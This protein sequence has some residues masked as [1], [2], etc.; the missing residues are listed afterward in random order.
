MG[1]AG[2]APP[3]DR[4]DVGDAA[5]AARQHLVAEHL[6]HVPG[7][8]EV[9]LDHRVPALRR[10][11]A[12]PLRELAA[13]VVHQQVNGADALLHPHRQGLDRLPVANVDELRL[14]ASPGRSTNLRRRL[15]QPL[16]RARRQHQIGAGLGE[17]L[18]NHTPEPGAAAGDQRGLSGQQ[19]RIEDLDRRRWWVH[20]LPIAYRL[21]HI[22]D[23]SPVPPND[24]RYAIRGNV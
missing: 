18:R 1:D 17:L 14:H 21:S 24:T 20:R 23:R 22:A 5:A 12:R 6:R 8:G 7:A 10:E 11:V 4:D 2:E 9:G 16:D 19:V 3:D 15:L 13:G